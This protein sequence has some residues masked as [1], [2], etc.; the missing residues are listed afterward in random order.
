MYPNTAQQVIGGSTSL[1]SIFTFWQTSEFASGTEKLLYSMSY[2]VYRFFL[3][4]PEQ[5][6]YDTVC[7]QEYV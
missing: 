3:N 6:L 2:S 1:S 7:I 4:D 5:L